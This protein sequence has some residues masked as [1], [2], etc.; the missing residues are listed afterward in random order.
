LKNKYGKRI[1]GQMFFEKKVIS[2]AKKIKNHVVTLPYWFWIGNKF[3]N[4]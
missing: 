2:F 3:L 4:V 1:F